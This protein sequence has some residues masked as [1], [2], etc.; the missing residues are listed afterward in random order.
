LIENTGERIKQLRM[1][2]GISLSQLSKDVDVSRS[3][4]SQVENGQALPSLPTLGRIVEALGV[5]LSEFFSEEVTAAICEEDIIVRKNYRKMIY[6]P[7]TKSKY[8]L[9]TANKHSK[10]EFFISEFPANG[11]GAETVP[12]VHEGEEYFYIISGKIKLTIGEK[13]YELEPGDSGSFDSSV[14]H[15]FSNQ[16]D[17]TAKVLFV[18][19]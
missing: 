13:T 3:M 17:E 5:S 9:L 11:G 4:L 2:K 8:Q 14:L 10:I 19:I 18:I 15:G 6:I 12:S 16:G 7:E 1:S